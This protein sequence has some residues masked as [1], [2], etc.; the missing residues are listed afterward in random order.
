MY[1][2]FDADGN[3]CISTGIGAAQARAFQQ[4]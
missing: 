3:V 4:S 1:H 2:F